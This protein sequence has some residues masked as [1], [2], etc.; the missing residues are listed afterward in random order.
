MFGMPNQNIV[1]I[2]IDISENKDISTKLSQINLISYKIQATFKEKILSDFG[3]STSS[4][5]LD[6]AIML[7][8][9]AFWQKWRALCI[10]VVRNINKFPNLL[11]VKNIQNNNNNNN[12]TYIQDNHT[13]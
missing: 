3:K 6:Y 5:T 2:G 12:N 7:R 9:H 13:T 10:I 1:R 8:K 11:K 4:T